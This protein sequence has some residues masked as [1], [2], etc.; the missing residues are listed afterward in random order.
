M[1]Q[2]T[3][4]SDHFC[5]LVGLFRARARTA[6]R[7]LFV[8]GL[9]LLA[10]SC[11]TIANASSTFD[12]TVPERW[13]EF[14]W[15]SPWIETGASYSE[16]KIGQFTEGSASF[17]GRWT[18]WAGAN[19][20]GDPTRVEAQIAIGTRS[21]V[22]RPLRYAPLSSVERP[23]DPALVDAFAGVSGNWGR[24]RF[25]LIPM[26]F[27]LEEGIESERRWLRPLVLRRG[28]IGLRDIGLGYSVS[29]GG[30]Y[31]D[32]YVHNGEG[33]DDRDREIWMTARW[34]YRLRTDRVLWRWGASGQVGRT[35]PDSTHPLG[36]TASTLSELDP[37]QSSK[38]RFGALHMASDWV[39]GEGGRGSETDRRF[40]FEFEGFGG[41]IEQ[42]ARSRRLRA[43]RLDIEYE[44]FEKWGFLLRGEML[45]P[46]TQL[47]GDMIHEA[48]FGVQYYM[49]AGALKRSLRALVVVTKE[50]NEAPLVVV[51]GAPDLTRHRIE[52][53]LRF[54]PDLPE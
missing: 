23:S 29:A 46:D 53:V 7:L 18:G 6:S 51:S 15:L 20:G 32:W 2:D 27:G 37:D 1:R 5:S 52:F 42:D 36:T 33:G 17:G 54:S 48:G 10:S 16:P 49:L 13:G 40:G 19:R 43:A 11:V 14:Q 44:P 34:E 3:D 12:A 24:L 31:S 21:L 45:D 41:E 28:L 26:T 30:F 22:A 50:W 38:L 47:A 25:G 8:L 9:T 39:I 4:Y 35:N